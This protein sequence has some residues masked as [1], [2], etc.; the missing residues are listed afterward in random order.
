MNLEHDHKPAP[1]RLPHDP[2]LFAYA[3]RDMRLTWRARGVLAELAAGYEPG[4]EPSVSAL[5]GL[6]RRNRGNAEGRDAL[7]KAIA[8]LRATGYLVPD[9]STANGVGERLVVDLSPAQD[10]LLLP[11]PRHF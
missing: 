8:E 7:G 4:Y 5:I 2:E 10:A 3:M 1:A 9:G 11:E 6:P